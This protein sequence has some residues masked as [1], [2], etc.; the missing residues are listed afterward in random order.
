MALQRWIAA[1]A[2]LCA[3]SVGVRAARG[4]GYSG[5][6]YQPS[7]PTFSPWLNLYQRNA[8][9]LDNYHTFVRP[10]RQLQ[11]TLRQQASAI[12]RQGE[13]IRGLTGQVND[14]REGRS[15][16]HPTGAGSVFMDYGHYYDWNAGAAPTRPAAPRLPA[17]GS[18]RSF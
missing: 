7:T 12:Q 18:R 2:V 6:G 9:P 5:S 15:P 4:Q 14:L 17:R 10:E 3:V 16:A 1:A 13:G 8:G 11:D